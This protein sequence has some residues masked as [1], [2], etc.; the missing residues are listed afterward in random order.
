MC[1]CEEVH[2]GQL[3]IFDFINGSRE[4]VKKKKRVPSTKSVE[5]ERGFIKPRRMGV[6]V[7]T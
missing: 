5:V 7:R 4:K 3:T 2:P 6:V 1:K